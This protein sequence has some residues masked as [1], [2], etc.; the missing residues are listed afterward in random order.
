MARVA[1]TVSLLVLVFA[2]LCSAVPAVSSGSVFTYKNEILSI[3]LADYVSDAMTPVTFQITSPPSLGT[4]GS[5]E[6][7]GVYLYK[8]DQGVVGI[9]EDSFAW[10]ATDSDGVSSLATMSISII[11]TIFPDPVPQVL[12]GIE[13]DVLENINLTATDKDTAA[14][15]LRYQVIELPLK[16]T[17]QERRSNGGIVLIRT[18][19]ILSPTQVLQYAPPSLGNGEDFA[20]FRYIA[21]D[22][23]HVSTSSARV[24]INLAP[25]TTP[26]I[27]PNGQVLTV[28]DN[29]GALMMS[30]C[31]DNCKSL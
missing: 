4:F 29:T 3:D 25:Y 30:A 26:P 10:T 12:N 6:N 1:I 9:D 2:G 15:N 5:I 21:H 28:P 18:T 13:G 11:D 22:G 19:T 31:H 16:G 27:V 24:Q 23:K 8:P 7:D 17:L 20:S 14:A